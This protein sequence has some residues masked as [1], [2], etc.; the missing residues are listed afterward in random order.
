MIASAWAWALGGIVVFLVV[1]LLAM[2][3]LGLIG[4]PGTF[5]RRVG[6]TAAGE[7][8][9]GGRPV[10]DEVPD[11]SAAETAARAEPPPDE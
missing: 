6:Q 11:A 4:L 3:A 5:A 10:P 1:G 9:E 7:R 2:L 8:S